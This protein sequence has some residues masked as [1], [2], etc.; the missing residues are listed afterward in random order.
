MWLV[1]PSL[2]LRPK[3]ET[4]RPAAHKPLRIRLTP[5]Q[6]AAMRRLPTATADGLR[7]LRDG[8][9]PPITRPDLWV[10]I[11]T[12]AIMLAADG[13]TERA[14]AR[15]WSSLEI[16]GCAAA[17]TGDDHLLG[18]AGL[19]AGRRVLNLTSVGVTVET[20]GAPLVLARRQT[21]GQRVHLWEYGR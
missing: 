17:R 19:L 8:V 20:A 6:H 2:F 11:A 4:A 7:I 9:P 13:W 18:V 1:Q 3:I 10:E 14:L 21:T 16:Y 12:D 5:D 15:G